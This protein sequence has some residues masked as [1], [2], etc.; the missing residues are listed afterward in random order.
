MR[1]SESHRSVDPPASTS[2]SSLHDTS[3]SY[4]NG[5]DSRTEADCPIC[6]ERLSYRLAGEKPH[7]MPTC[8]HALHNACFTAV[9]GKPEDILAAQEGGSSG[10]K[11]GPPGMCGVCRKAIVLGGD[12]G[13]NSRS[14]SNL[15]DDPIGSIALS[16]TMSRSTSRSYPDPQSSRHSTMSSPASRN[17]ILEANSNH[18]SL[19]SPLPTS[20][21]SPGMVHP[22]IRI[23]PEFDTIYRKDP[24]GQNGKQNIVCVVALEVPSRRPPLSLDEQ[25]AKHQMQWKGLP[26]LNGDDDDEQEATDEED[27]DG[28]I[29]NGL[30]AGDEPPAEMRYNHRASGLSESISSGHDRA[31]ASSDVGHER[32]ARHDDQNSLHEYGDENH[33]G[34]GKETSN[35]GDEDFSMHAAPAIDETS[36][37]AVFED[38]KARLADWK[39][40]PIEKFG[41]LALYDYIGIS[42]DNVVRKFWVYLFN[43]ALICVTE[44]G[45]P[46]RKLSRLGSKTGSD[47]GK[48]TKPPKLKLKGRIWLRHISDMIEKNV[49]GS[50]SLAITLDDDTLGNFVLVF[51]TEGIRQAW[52]SKVESLADESKASYNS[53]HSAPGASVANG[54][55]TANDS[56]GSVGR[57]PLSYEQGPPHT[58][59]PSKSSVGATARSARSASLIS[60]KSGSEPASARAKQPRKSKSTHTLSSE[61][62]AANTRASF[63]ASLPT[64]QQ[65]SA[66]GGLDPS[67]PPPKLLP[68]APLDLVLMVSVPVVLQK[69]TSGVSSSAALKLRLIRSTL[70]FVSS[71]MGPSDRLAVVTY[72]SGAEGDV[73][74]TGLLSITARER[75]RA[76]LQDFIESIGKAWDED[77]DDPYRVDSETLGGASERTDTVTALNV[78]LDIVLSRKVKNSMTGMILIN[79]TT[80]GP[81]KRQMDLVMARAEAAN[82]PIHCFGFGKSSNPSSLWL[83]SNHT[84]GSYTFVREWYQLRECIAGCIGSIM[85]TAIDQFKLRISVP[86]DNHFRVKKVQGV[87]NPVVSSSGKHVD[88]EVGELRYG[89]TR[90]LFVELELDIN[91]LVPFI[92]QTNDDGRVG[93]VRKVR[94]APAIEVGSATDDFIQRLGLSDLNLED[95][96][97]SS[98]LYGIDHSMGSLIEEVA[99]FEVDAAYRDVTAGSS[100]HRLSNPSVLTLEVDGTAPENGSSNP[101]QTSDATVTRRRIEL[102][103]SDMITRSLL[104]VS[105][106]NYTQALR[107]IN[108]THK[109]VETVLARLTEA[110]AGKESDRALRRRAA[111]QRALVQDQAI[112]SLLAILDDLELTS[113]GLQLGP[114]GHFERD[115]RNAAAQQAMVLRDQQAW[116]TRT[117]TEALRFLGD[118]GPALAAVA[119]AD[120]R[121]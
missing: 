3:T 120:S 9:Y 88:V 96:A 50:P 25:E 41:Q 98:D 74:K 28:G 71:H 109:I 87:L 121:S 119:Y 33:S 80:D 75:S 36:Y 55:T 30:E 23:R 118:N 14:A 99:V 111:R 107:I 100:L 2:G 11:A 40:Q 4:N 72:S 24:T 104:L 44:S 58:S 84:R 101:Q 83:I 114:R 20:P 61:R 18:E 8:G 86:S 102:L 43:S 63:S 68:H 48:P 113:N 112:V 60:G 31:L 37:D 47:K 70:E 85:S 19:S 13:D 45:K 78:G 22:V 67:M 21:T 34:S 32:L 15:I 90:E 82:T 1:R 73:R 16:S 108:E 35:G 46:D 59:T 42:Q 64:Q 51:P 56:N 94:N 53:R 17:V 7:V 81:A 52:R 117:T 6:L 92:A 91:G 76:K 26:L 65:W 115:G 49:Q 93:G 103:V 116:T 77:E 106:K 62:D 54:V 5:D 10:K 95:T 79:D 110:N 27:A 105:R 12:G 89:E 29:D 66:S 57:E 97:G 69:D 39:G 38:L